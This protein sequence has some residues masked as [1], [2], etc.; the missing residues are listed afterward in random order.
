MQDVPVAGVVRTFA[1]ANTAVPTLPPWGNSCVR[2]EEAITGSTGWSNRCFCKCWSAVETVVVGPLI[3]LLLCT[4]ERAMMPSYTI[5]S[6]EMFLGFFTLKDITKL[7]SRCQGFKGH[8]K[9]LVLVI[10]VFLFL[11]FSLVI[12]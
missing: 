9:T 10:R 7:Q 12:F 11:S 6:F 2:P 4:N 1:G 3:Y 5:I 8:P